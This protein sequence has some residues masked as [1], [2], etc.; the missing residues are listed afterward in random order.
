V[1]IVVIFQESHF[2]AETPVIV[3][4]RCSH[5]A[6]NFRWSPN[7]ARAE[8]AAFRFCKPC[9]LSFHVFQSSTP[10]R[11]A[12]S[13]HVC[14]KLRRRESVSRKI[15]AAKGI[16]IIAPSSIDIAKCSVSGQHE[17]R[18]PPPQLFFELSKSD[19]ARRAKPSGR[20]IHPFVITAQH[21]K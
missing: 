11:F 18:C 2:P 19:Q 3:R 7:F 20:Y 14:A 15:R 10:S 16:P 17:V 4:G 9:R 5:W 8:F 1:N 6:A 21:S 12:K 13:R